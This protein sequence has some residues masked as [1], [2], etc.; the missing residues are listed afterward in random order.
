MSK[1][2]N[3]DG[4]VYKDASRDRWIGE[5]QDDGKRRRVTGKTKS[6]ALAKMKKRQAEVATGTDVES[7]NVRVSHVLTRFLSRTLPNRKGGDL[8]PATLALHEWASRIITDP[9]NGLGSKRVSSLKV[10]D[11]ERFL[12]RLVLEEGLSFRSV[13]Q[14]RTTLRMALDDSVKRREMISNVARLADIHPK[15]PKTTRTQRSL[16]P[17]MVR[18]LLAVLPSHPLGPMWL[19]MVRLGLRWEEA[20]AIHWDSLD[21]DRLAIRHTIRRN[22]GR[23]EVVPEMKNEQSRRIWTLPSDVVEALTA[24]RRTQAEHRLSSPSWGRPELVFTNGRGNPLDYRRSLDSFRSFCTEHGI[25]VEDENGFRAPRLHELRHTSIEMAKRNGTNLEAISRAMGH[26]DVRM[27]QT[28]YNEPSTEPIRV[29]VD[30]DWLG[31]V[32]A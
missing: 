5:W 2:S 17:E 20:S 11:V 13:K 6:D 1:R 30:S 27:I 4:S 19:L 18:R 3:G 12:D 21:G 22:R 24:H 29:L 8:A 26:G 16:S 23:S 14:V 31:T 32:T 9:K 7:R 28:A 25:V 10:S 15:A